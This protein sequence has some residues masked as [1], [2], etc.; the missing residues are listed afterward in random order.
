MIVPPIDVPTD[1]IPNAKDLR[2]LNHCE[3]IEGIGLKIIPQQ[4]PVRI[5]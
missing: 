3:A 5:P 2:F 1:M 4:I